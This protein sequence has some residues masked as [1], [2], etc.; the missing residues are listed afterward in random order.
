MAQSALIAADGKLGVGLGHIS[1]CRALQAELE[2][3]EFEAKLV[4]T[5]ELE[6]NLNQTLWDLI[7]IDSY[8]L[9]LEAYEKVVRCAKTCLFF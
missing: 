4:D 9:P 2:S 8:V 5:Q 3:L 7:A 1:R 6:E